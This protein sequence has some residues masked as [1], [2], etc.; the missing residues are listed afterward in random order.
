MYFAFS[1]RKKDVIIIIQSNELNNMYIEGNHKE[2][3]CYRGDNYE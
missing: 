2:I 3:I 1:Y